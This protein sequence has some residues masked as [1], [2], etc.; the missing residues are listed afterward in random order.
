MNR[1]K[2]TLYLLA[3]FAVTQS[4]WGI[5]KCTAADG[6]VAFQDAPCQGKG[7][8]IDVKPAAGRIMPAAVAASGVKIPT[9][10]QRLEAVIAESQRTRR[11]RD[12]QE[13]YYPQSRSDVLQ[14]R[15]TCTQEQKDLAAK[16]YAYVQNLYGKTHAAQIASEM[17]A[18]SSR[19]ELKDRELLASEAALKAEC[20]KL[21]GCK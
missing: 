17:A 3:A 19:C 6:T 4:A 5:S 18:A 13:I 9:E 20:S 7:S 21:G 10:A 8:A 1:F 15:Q 2:C 14:H 16:Q 12:L 11:L